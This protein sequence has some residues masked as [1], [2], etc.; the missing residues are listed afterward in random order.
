M[1][2]VVYTCIIF[3]KTF[4]FVF[5]CFLFLQI[6]LFLHLLS[7]KLMYVTIS[8][9]SILTFLHCFLLA[10]IKNRYFRFDNNSNIQIS[11][12]NNVH[13]R[14]MI[15]SN[16]E[17]KLTECGGEKKMKTIEFSNIYQSTK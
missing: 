1:K 6:Q 2:T 3:I 17:K 9:N 4:Y 5:C 16:I 7:I 10:F 14:Y 15:H 13:C 8:L 11:K 12:C